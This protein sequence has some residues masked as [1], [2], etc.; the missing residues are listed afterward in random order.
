MR[1]L[2]TVPSQELLGGVAI[3]Y[4][5]LRKYLPAQAEYFVVGARGPQE[6]FAQTLLRLFTDCR[7]FVAKL[8]QGQYDLVHINPSLTCKAVI[9]DG[10]LLLLAHLLGHKVLVFFHGWD[11]HCEALVARYFRLFFRLVYFRAN[12]IIVLAEEFAGRLRELGFDGPIH[13]ETTVAG[14]WIIERSECQ[15][16]PKGHERLETCHILYMSRFEADK[17][18]P[19]TL[20]IFKLLKATHPKISLTMAGDGSGLESARYFVAQH[21]LADVSLPGRVDGDD[22]ASLLVH[23][24]IFFFPT[25]YGEGMP[26]AVLE[27]MAAGLPVVTCKVGGIRDFFEDGVMGFSTESVSIPQLS[28]HLETLITNP[29]LRQRMGAH[30]RA[31]AK[32][33]FAASRVAARL[34]DI[35]RS[36]IGDAKP[37]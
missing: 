21:H 5:E 25:N 34:V 24:N 33:R 36:T 1:V 3:Y 19:E 29:S 7:H 13:V 17:G 27:A 26:L 37:N 32:E 15:R 4:R 20:E 22:K 8:R 23:S 12:A 9:R 2:V 35:Y 30:N 10:M 31:Y 14:D 16:L 11:K 6:G 28:A 18:A